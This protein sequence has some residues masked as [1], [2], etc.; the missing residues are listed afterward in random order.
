M[1]RISFPFADDERERAR[2]GDLQANGG[3]GGAEDQ[4]CFR[5]MFST[6]FL[7]SELSTFMIC[8]NEIPD[9]REDIQRRLKEKNGELDVEEERP[10]RPKKKKE[11]VVKSSDDEFFE[12]E[13]AQSE[14]L[15]V[16]ISFC[17]LNIPCRFSSMKSIFQAR[18][19]SI[20]L[21][22]VPIPMTSFE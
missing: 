8:V 2:T 3:N 15:Y 10:S 19:R 22:E 1:F 11:K 16:N 20:S 5:S 21:P 12:E 9:F 17:F 6:I 18:R 7:P 13:K 14:F 4:V